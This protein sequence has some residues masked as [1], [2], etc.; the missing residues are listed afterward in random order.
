MACADD[1]QLKKQ[2]CSQDCYEECPGT[3]AVI[4]YRPRSK[5]KDV[6]LNESLEVSLLIASH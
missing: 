6:S 1:D 2:V 5:I 4:Q 3:A